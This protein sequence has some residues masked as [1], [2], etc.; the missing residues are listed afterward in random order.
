MSRAGW[1]VVDDSQSLVFDEE[2]WLERAPRL[3]AD[4]TIATSTSSATA[5]ITPAACRITRRVSGHVPMIPRCA[6]GNWWSRYWDYRAGRAAR[7]DA[8]SS[9]SKQM[10]L[11]VCIIDMDW[12]ITE[13]GNASSGWTGYT[14]NR[15]LFPDP[16]GFIAWL[17]EQGL[18]T[19]LNLHPAEGVWPHEAQYEAMAQLHGA[20]TRRR[21]EPVPLRLRRPAASSRAISRSCTTRWRP[22]ASISGGWTGSRA[23]A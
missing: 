19:A 9:A 21:G 4:T 11:S 16:H 23:S 2:G 12:H 14:W 5:T 22:R 6:L 13:T 10:P 8:A 3:A 17:H 1:A 7:P 15:E 18:R 20:A